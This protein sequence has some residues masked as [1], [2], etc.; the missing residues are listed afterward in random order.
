M[1]VCDIVQETGIKTIPKKKK[2]K[3]AKWLSEEALQ[4]AIKRREVKSKGGKERYKHLNAEFQIIARRDKKAFLSNQCKEIEENRMGKTR[5]LFKKIKDT[6]GTFHAKM[7]SM[8]DRNGM[9]LKEAEDVKKRWKEYTE[10]LYKK[11]LH[12]PDNHDGV[13]IDLEPD[14]LECEVK[15]ALK[16][17]TANKASGGDRIPVELFQILKDDAVKVLQ[18]ICQHIWK[19]QQWPQDWKRSVFIPI[20]KKGNAKEA[21]TTTQLHSSHTLVK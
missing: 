13:I 3:K 12:D 11:D 6:K 18:S 2:C 14:I 21:Q 9:D 19:T 15:W 17:I 20:P 7:G 5:D 16:S 8:K 4:I 1:E 10:E